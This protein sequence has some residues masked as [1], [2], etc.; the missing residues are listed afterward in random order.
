MYQALPP[1]LVDVLPFSTTAAAFPRLWAAGAPPDT[2]LPAELPVLCRELS[3]QSVLP[4]L[5][6]AHRVDRPARSRCRNTFPRGRPPLRDRHPGFHR[7]RAVSVSRVS[8]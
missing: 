5:L 2:D 7:G 1:E 4:S 8:A 3:M 6:R